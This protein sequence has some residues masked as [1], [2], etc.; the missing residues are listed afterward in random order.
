MN[1]IK[2]ILQEISWKNVRNLIDF[3]RK[4]C[5]TMLIF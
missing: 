3:M 2:E 5:R 4:T 1:A